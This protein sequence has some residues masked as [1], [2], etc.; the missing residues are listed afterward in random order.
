MQERGPGCPHGHSCARNVPLASRGATL[1]KLHFFYLHSLFWL[2]SVGE[3]TALSADKY[4]I[5]SSFFLE[6]LPGFP[7]YCIA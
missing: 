3:L 5:A 6:I 7:I 4:F 2:D 1:V